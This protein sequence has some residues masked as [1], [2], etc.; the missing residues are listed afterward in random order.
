[1]TEYGVFVKNREYT[2]PVTKEMTY[3]AVK[4]GLKDERIIRREKRGS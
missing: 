3:N 1:M 2:L 4:Q